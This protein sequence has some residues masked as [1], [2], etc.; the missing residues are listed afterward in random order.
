MESGSKACCTSRDNVVVDLEDGGDGGDVPGLH[1]EVT[2]EGKVKLLQKTCLFEGCWGTKH[3][4]DKYRFYIQ[5]Y[6]DFIYI[7]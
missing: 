2:G 3:L 4:I 1:G 5:I 6:T 7:H